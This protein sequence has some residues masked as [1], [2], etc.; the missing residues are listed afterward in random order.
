MRQAGPKLRQ[1]FLR[2]D[3]IFISSEVLAALGLSDNGS[4]SNNF[5]ESEILQMPLKSRMKRYSLIL[6]KF[7]MLY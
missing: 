6:K 7:Y 2:S 3:V 5:R 1:S 4:I